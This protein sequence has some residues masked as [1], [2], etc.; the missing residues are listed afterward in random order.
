M[1]MD[2]N[3][4]TLMT[5]GEVADYLRLKER[6]VYEMAARHQIPCSRATGKLLFSR[7]LVDSWIEAHTEM[8]AG[9]GVMAPPIYAGSSEPLLE[10][11]LRQSGAGLA[12]LI[13]G[14]RFGLEAIAQGEAALAGIHMI[15]P[16][17]GDYNLPQVRAVVPHGDVVVIHWARRSQGLMLAP[18]N[19]HGITGLRDAVE[20]GLRIARRPEGSG[21]ALLLG[22]LLAREGLYPED[23]DA[24]L[25]AD[26]QE[27]LAGMIAMGDA[28][29]GLGIASVAAGLELIPVAQEDFDL[30]MR[31]RDYFEPPV[32][33]LLAFCRTDLFQRRAEFIGGYD[34]SS[35]GTVRY[36]Y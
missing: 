13:A 18:G 11:T 14:S 30:V 3:A 12:T 17:T 23:V 10:W 29:C 9:L 1:I 15:D 16:D 6:T 2:D 27:D 19:P 32:Q 21:S 28:D 33:A 8:P 20:R 24:A 25:V 22:N 5:T 35:L 7:K 26:S 31:R 4:V 34:L 36:N